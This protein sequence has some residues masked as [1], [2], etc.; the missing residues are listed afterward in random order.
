MVACE[1]RDNRTGKNTQHN[2][3]VLLRQ[4]VYHSLAGYEDTKDAER[5]IAPPTGWSFLATNASVRTNPPKFHRSLTQLPLCLTMAPRRSRI[6]YP[7]TARI[8][9]C[10]KTRFLPAQSV[11]LQY[12]SGRKEKFVVSGRPFERSRFSNILQIDENYLDVNEQ[13]SS[14]QLCP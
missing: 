6:C 4:A 12:F 8:E 3:L 13:I 11:L 7:K 9:P 5:Q 2:L 14:L 1:F 10:P